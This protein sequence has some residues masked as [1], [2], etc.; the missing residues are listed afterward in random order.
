MFTHARAKRKIEEDLLERTI[1][2]S[3]Q[4]Q[5]ETQFPTVDKRAM[6]DRNTKTSCSSN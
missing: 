6:Q 3:S 4:T 5:T 1:D 2:G